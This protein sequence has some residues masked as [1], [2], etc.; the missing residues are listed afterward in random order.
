MTSALDKQ[1]SHPFACF[2]SERAKTGRMCASAPT[3][4]G[5]TKAAAPPTS[6]QPALTAA[7]RNNI[8]VPDIL[9]G[10]VLRNVL[11]MTNSHCSVVSVLRSSGFDTTSND[12]TPSSFSCTYHQCVVCVCP[13]LGSQKRMCLLGHLIPPKSADAPSEP[14]RGHARFVN[15]I[16][17]YG[18]PVDRDWSALCSR[19]L[20]FGRAASPRGKFPGP[21][22]VPTVPADDLKRFVFGDPHA[23]RLQ[24]N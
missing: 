23:S 21:P 20:S 3:C 10:V 5:I 1:S 24:R 4:E 11:G 17:Q 2:T 9:R 19:P 6:K 12:A 7:A 14:I 15:Q 16:D 13:S 8:L 18:E 22:V